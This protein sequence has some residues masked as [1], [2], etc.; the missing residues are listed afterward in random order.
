MHKLARN[1]SRSKRSSLEEIGLELEVEQVAAEEKRVSAIQRLG[2][3]EY[4]SRAYLTLVKIGASK[5]SELSFFAQIPRSKAYGTL[6]ELARKGLIHVIPGKPELYSAVSPNDALM[7]VLSKLHRRLQDSEDIVLEL[8]LVHEARKYAKQDLPRESVEFWETS[9]RQPLCSRLNQALLEATESI[10]LATTAAGLIRAYKAQSELLE[11]ALIRGVN[12]RLVA[13]MS[14]DN[15]LVAE[16]FAEIVPMRR[17]DQPLDINF[18]SVDHQLLV[19]IDSMPEDSSVDHGADIAVWT[20]NQLLIALHEQ[21]FE[22][23]W[24]IL[25]TLR[26]PA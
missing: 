19:V 22:H 24:H 15:L 23:L 21:F 9:G 16:Q 12:V 10:S 8:N 2:L 4:E 14:P 25:P 17:L 7:P 26:I 11:K 20:T 6:K 5:A 18:I 3:T 1:H 13:P